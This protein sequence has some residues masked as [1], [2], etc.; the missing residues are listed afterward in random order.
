MV[1]H[2]GCGLP[3]PLWLTMLR[4]FSCAY[5]PFA[6][7]FYGNVYS[8][9]LPISS[10]G[11]LSLYCWVIK[12]IYS[13]DIST[14]KDVQFAN[15]FSPSMD[16]SFTFLIVFF[17]E[18]KVLILIKSNSS[19]FPLSLMLLMSS[20]KIMYLILTCTINRNGLEKKCYKIRNQ[21]KKIIEDSNPES[22]FL[23]ERNHKH[24]TC[25]W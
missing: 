23:Q 22:I 3:F 18:Q 6:H 12:V 14:S 19:F 17:K 5:P 24:N 7:L 8:N 11:C 10:L 9:H 13:L 25:T 15:I 16:C 2:C 21:S 1:S 4:N 20:K